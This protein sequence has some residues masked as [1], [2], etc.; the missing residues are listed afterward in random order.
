MDIIKM[1]ENEIRNRYKDL[2]NANIDIDDLTNNH[3]CKIFEYYSCIKLTERYKTPFYEYAY[4]DNNFKEENQLSQ[5]DTGIDCCNLIDTIVQCKLRKN[6]LTWKECG[7]F[8]ASQNIFDEVNNTTIVKWQKLIITRNDDCTLSANLQFRSKLF[9]DI[10]YN[11]NEMIKYC[12]DLVGN[13]PPL[14]IEPKIKYVIRDYQQECIDLINNSNENVIISLP[15]GTGKNFIITH[16]LKKDKKYLIV[17]PR[18]ILM[19]Q[20]KA[21][22]KKHKP[23][24]KSQIQLIGGG[25]TTFDI[26]KDITICVY[27]SVEIV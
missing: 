26:T 27:N 14:P 6:T 12:Q 7:T 4:I 11:K 19:E 8:F 3:L 13:Q 20:I 16:S 15:T 9:T 2:L 17:V 5:N 1:Y 21:E 24:L 22:I 23:K 25:N 10:L 18:I